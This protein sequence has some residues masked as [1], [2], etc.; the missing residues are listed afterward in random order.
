MKLIREYTENQELE[1]LAEAKEDGRKTYRIKGP[2]VQAEIKNGNG[3][4][5]PNKV[6][7]EQVKLYS[8]NKIKRKNAFGELDHPPTPTI[9]MDRVSHIIESLEMNGNDGIGVA[10]IL[11]TTTGK[12][13]EVFLDAGTQL[14]VSSRG[15]GSIRGNVVGEDYK[16]LTVDIV[17][18]PS[19]P[20]AFVDGIL[21]NKEYIMEGN[22]FVEKAIEDFQKSLDKT[23]SKYI[24]EN[25]MT[26][27]AEVRNN[28]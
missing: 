5:Y 23:G 28:L 11:P 7:T 2:F 15:V 16:L 25:L 10:R 9:N 1:F 18:D 3:R 22:I 24:K 20:S 13:V 21:E 14:G 8:E 12:L 26:F 27:L 19:A 4:I 6:L 17:A